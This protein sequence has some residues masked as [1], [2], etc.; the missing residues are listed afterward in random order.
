MF[1]LQPFSKGVHNG[2][3]LKNKPQRAA[4]FVHIK[5]ASSNTVS[6]VLPNN[7]L[8]NAVKDQIKT[9]FSKQLHLPFLFICSAAWLFTD[10]R[11]MRCRKSHKNLK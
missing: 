2:L 1:S 4:Y 7:N 8:F 5:T 6:E 11:E 10:G 9:V 3:A